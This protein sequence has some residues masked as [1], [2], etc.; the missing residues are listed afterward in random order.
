MADKDGGFAEFMGEFREFRGEVHADLGN[1]KDHIGAVS[2]KA[3]RVRE[4]FQ[5]HAKDEHAH[6]LGGER[7]GTGRVMEVISWGVGV[8]GG[9]FALAAWIGKH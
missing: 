8:G 4:E 3:D 5:D 6:G 9:L 7:R 2:K 1:I